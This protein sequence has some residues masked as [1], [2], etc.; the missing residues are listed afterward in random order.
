[1]SGNPRWYHTI[2]LAPGEVTP[3]LVDLRAVAPAVLPSTVSGRALDVGTFDGFWAFELEARGASEVVAIDVGEADEAQWP[4]PHRERLRREAAELGLEL[5]LGFRIA[6]EARGSAARRVVC[7]VTALDASRIGGPVDLAF[8]GA[9]LLHLRDPVG[10]LERVLA[11][12][13]PGGRL[14]LLEPVAPGTGPVARFQALETSFNWW[15][16]TADALREWVFAAGFDDVRIAGTHDVP[17]REG[18]G[19]PHAAVEAVRP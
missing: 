4:P 2:E 9:L 15:L 19:V 1:M 16:P 12:L 18:L 11:S 17:G 13:V 14:V 10:A 8:V 7:D 3:G 6:A 5:G